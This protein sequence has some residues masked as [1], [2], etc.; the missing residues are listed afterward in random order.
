MGKR[1]KAPILLD[2]Q[3]PVDLVD[4]QAL[5][6]FSVHHKG[7][8]MAKASS[9]VERLIEQRSGDDET[10][11]PPDETL[12]KECPETWK[13]LTWKGQ[14]TPYVK[15]PAVV[16]ITLGV[17]C[18]TVTISD[19]DAMVSM[20]VTSLRFQDIPQALEKALSGPNPPLKSW[21]GKEPHFRERKKPKKD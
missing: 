2:T 10:Q 7:E 8:M 21:K 18:W 15:E 19:G 6:C 16:R 13:W 17:G 11:L 20:D 9:V 14:G 1:R 3:E 12:R 5:E 4:Q